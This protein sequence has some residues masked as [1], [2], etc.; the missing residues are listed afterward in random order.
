MA[1][2]SKDFAGGDTAG[3]VAI[4][5]EGFAGPYAYQVL[6]PEDGEALATWLDDEG[7]S[8]GD[9]AST[10]D[11]YIEEG[12]YSFVAI[13]LAPTLGE[14]PGEG[15]FLPALAIDSDSEQLHFPAR[16][17][18]TGMAEELRTTIWVLGEE[19]AEITSG[20]ASESTGWLNSGEDGDAEAAFDAAL[21][22]AAAQEIP[23]YLSPYS[24]E[25]E[26]QWVTRFDTLAPR[27]VHTA[28]PIFDFTGETWTWYLEIEVP[29]EDDEEASA[30]TAAWILLPFLGLG[31]SRRRRSR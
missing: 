9:T 6:D 3:G 26:G 30:R 8:L 18:L 23:T 10:V 29:D 17:S 15:R 5:A 1:M 4:T 16:M 14:T 13:S 31:W 12:G 2:N 19:S 20:W 25:Y 7:F 11:E 28:D 24:G 27:D 22:V 21:Q